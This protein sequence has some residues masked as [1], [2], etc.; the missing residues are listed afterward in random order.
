LGFLASLEPRMPFSFPPRP[1]RLAGAFALA[2]ALLLLAAV[3]ARAAPEAGFQRAYLL[4]GLASAGESGAIDKAADAFESLLRAEP[5][6]PVL[7]AYVG[8]IISMKARTTLLP[9][10][11]MA[12]AEDGLA[13]I[14]KALA[15][16][17]P[18][19]DAPL[20]HGTPGTLEVKFVAA[21]TFLAVPGFMNRAE[22][23][24]KLLAEVTAS[25]LFVTAPLPFRGGV[26]MRA[27]RLAAANKRPADA[28]R[29]LDQVIISG[30]PQ[31]EAARA[32][33]KETPA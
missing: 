31:A 15:L 16:L 3:G 17:T 4:F 26:W 28:R 18:A 10:R 21:N 8:A 9:W 24:A 14:D 27:A 19:H 23:G 22:R 12:L 20:Q 30:A 6:N 7:R 25:P 33:L 32:L 13:Q 1:R 2:A 11:K 5:A 29:W